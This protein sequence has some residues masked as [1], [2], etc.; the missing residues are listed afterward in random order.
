[1]GSSPNGTLHP[2]VLLPRPVELAGPSL[3]VPLLLFDAGPLA[4]FR[5]PCPGGKYGVGEPFPFSVLGLL[6]KA[7]G[8]VAGGGTGGGGLLPRLSEGGRGV[9]ALAE[10]EFKKSCTSFSVAGGRIMGF[11]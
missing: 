4:T 1:L 6:N 10:A 7:G 8:A 11:P 5:F 3:E 2:E 9:D